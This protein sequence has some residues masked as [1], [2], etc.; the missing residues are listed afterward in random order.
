MKTQVLA[1]AIAAIIL[2]G[3]ST[4]AIPAQT[5][6]TCNG[7]Q[8]GRLQT[9][10]YTTVYCGNSSNHTDYTW[11]T[12]LHITTTKVEVGAWYAPTRTFAGYMPVGAGNSTATVCTTLVNGTRECL[13]S[14]FRGLKFSNE[15]YSV[16][17]YMYATAT[18]NAPTS[19][20]P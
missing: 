13:Y 18:S 15:R 8:W 5:T 11:A 14:S 7:P 12:V 2:L 16:Y 1:I 4:A 20:T 17:E 3:I 9:N 6:V 10:P 19:T